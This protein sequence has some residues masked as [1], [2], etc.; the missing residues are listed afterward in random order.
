MKEEGGLR[1]HVRS[2]GGRGPL[3]VGEQRGEGGGLTRS[4][5]KTV[6]QQLRGQRAPGCGA[7]FSEGEDGR[8]TVRAMK[9]GGITIIHRTVDDDFGVNV[10]AAYQ[11]ANLIGA[12]AKEIIFTSGATESNNL[13]IKVGAGSFECGR[14]DSSPS[15]GGT[16]PLPPFPPPTHICNSLPS[17]RVWQ[18]S[19][20]TRRSTSSRRRRSTS[21][22]WTHAGVYGG[23]W[24]GGGEEKGARAALD[25]F[26]SLSFC[27]AHRFLSFCHPGVGRQKPFLLTS[28][29]PLPTLQAPA[30]AG[31]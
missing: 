9:A 12:D 22:C 15:R 10:A 11:V 2:E 26:P 16:P 24:G 8:T 19:T 13:A 4:G 7:V 28:P 21:V 6:Q 5:L 18:T 20:R 29:P 25:A 14:E 27:K 31:L 23:G 30:A 3:A 1:Q 17:R